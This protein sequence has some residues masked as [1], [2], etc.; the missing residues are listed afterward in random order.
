MQLTNDKN[1]KEKYDENKINVDLLEKV[2]ASCKD[3][4]N[5]SNKRRQ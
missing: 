3:N 1:D 2:I 5:N 4:K